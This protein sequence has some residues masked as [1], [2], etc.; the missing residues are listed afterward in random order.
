[1]EFSQNT[2]D[3][4]EAR[5]CRHYD[6]TR[7]SEKNLKNQAEF[8]HAVGTRYHSVLCFPPFIYRP[9]CKNVLNLCILWSQH[10]QLTSGISCSSPKWI[11]T[12]Q[13]PFR[14][15][16]I[17]VGGWKLHGYYQKGDNSSLKTINFRPARQLNGFR[18]RF[19]VGVFPNRA[20]V[21]EKLSSLYR[22][23]SEGQYIGI[24]R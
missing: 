13:P 18:C 21:L 23:N 15:C 20:N 6:V 19:P 10:A 2:N 8:L 14:S 24:L 17:T 1:M 11:E 9:P 7:K 3:A 12:L 22:I 4:C 5:I 16:P